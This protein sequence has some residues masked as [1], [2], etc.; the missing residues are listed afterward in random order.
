M[1]IPFSDLDITQLA[2]KARLNKIYLQVTMYK[3]NRE[4][5]AHQTIAMPAEELS[6]L[7]DRMQN[8]TI[9]AIM[10][11]RYQGC[12]CCAIQDK[13]KER[14]DALAKAIGIPPYPD[15]S[16]YDFGHSQDLI[17]RLEKLK[18]SP[19]LLDLDQESMLDVLALSGE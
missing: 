14:E 15:G 4:K 18:A 1:N 10:A 13:L 8:I 7:W 19:T 16:G 11:L 2:E 5:A 6:W 3:N 17:L 12:G 9:T